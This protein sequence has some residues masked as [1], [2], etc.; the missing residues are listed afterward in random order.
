MRFRAREVQRVRPTAAA[1]IDLGGGP[2]PEPRHTSG[3]IVRPPIAYACSLLSGLVLDR[4]WTLPLPSSD[5]LEGAGAVLVVASIA[6][7]AR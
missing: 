7:F 2:S 4:I 5:V 1:P 6:L 3:P